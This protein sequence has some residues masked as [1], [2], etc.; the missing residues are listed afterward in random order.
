M[1][2]KQTLS[3][4]THGSYP[5]G[6]I[7]LDRNKKIE[8]AKIITNERLLRREVKLLKSKITELEDVVKGKNKVITT[9]EDKASTLEK[10]N[11]DHEV[12]ES[13]LKDKVKSTEDN[14]RASQKASSNGL[15]LWSTLGSSIITDTDGRKTGG[16]GLGIVK[17]NAL[18][19]VGVNPLNPKLEV[20]VTLGV[21]LFKL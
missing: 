7:I 9:L 10:M 2:G 5:S 14:V 20:V 11:K 17:Y 4:Q 21:K 8:I 1:V 13:I 18:L 6:S 16:I 19:G 3:S 12:L 15:Y